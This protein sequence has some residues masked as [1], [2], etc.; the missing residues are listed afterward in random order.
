MARV[1]HW[2]W[3]AIW[4]ICSRTV[5]VCSKPI[6]DISDGDDYAVIMN[7][8][9]VYM[10]SHSI[11]LQQTHKWYFRWRWLE[12]CL[13][14]ASH[15]KFAYDKSMQ[16]MQKKHQNDNKSWEIY[17]NY[18]KDSKVEKSTNYFLQ[19]MFSCLC[20]ISVYNCYLCQL[21]VIC[22]KTLYMLWVSYLL[23]VTKLCLY[24]MCQLFVIRHK[25]CLYISTVIKYIYFT[26]DNLKF[27]WGT[28]N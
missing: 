28:C 5:Y 25:F 21:F 16:I 3:I 15:T 20:V 17:T 12:P 8:Y 18:E 19:N 2:L 9:M 1:M 26:G 13:S 7:R 24:I 27:K 23:S 4:C 22:H 11:C 6:N 10:Q 14:P